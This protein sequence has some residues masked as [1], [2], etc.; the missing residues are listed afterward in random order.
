MTEPDM[1][2]HPD[3]YKSPTGLETIDV[4][5]AFGLGFHAGNA[6]KYILRAGRKGDRTEDLKKA[7]WYLNRLIGDTAV[8]VPNPWTAPGKMVRGM[9]H[10]MTHG[11]TVNVTVTNKTPTGPDY[12]AR[13]WA[14]VEDQYRRA[15]APP[16]KEVAA[17]RHRQDAKW[18]GPNH[19]DQHTTAEFIQWIRNYAGWAEMMDSMGSPD[20]ARRRLIQ[21]A[22][23][24]VAAVESMDRKETARAKERR[25]PHPAPLADPTSPKGPAS[26]G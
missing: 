24:A 16:L 17:E 26:H 23:L 20:K 12:E 4:I 7:R 9:A 3:H 25:A 5:E 19:D 14:A 6:V 22:A 13:I 2:N 21:V 10:D 8:A 15:S 1:V 11:G 18:G